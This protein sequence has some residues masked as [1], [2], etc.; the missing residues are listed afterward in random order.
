MNQE[1]ARQLLDG[2]ELRG[3]GT[4]ELFIDG[5][6]FLNFSGCNYLALTNNREL[7][8]AAQQAL[9]EGVGFS[10]YLVHAYGGRDPYFDAVEKEA[11]KFFG[12]EAAVYLPSGYMIG[13][14]GFAAAAPE[15]DV[16]LL[17]E[18]AHWCL[19]DAAKLTEKPI[20]YFAHRSAM[21][22]AEE[23][24]KLA[25]DQRPLVVTDGAFATLGALPPLDEYAALLRPLNGR[26]LVD[27]SHSG[28]VVGESGRGTV[29]HFGVE[30]IAHVGVTLSKAFC[31]QGAVYVGSLECV[32]RARACTPVRGSNSGT[33]ISANVCAAA[34]RFVRANPSLCAKVRESAEYLRNRLRG[35]GLDVPETPTSIV[36]FSH[37][38][39]SDMRAIQE[40]LFDKGIY[41]LHSNYIASGPGGIIRLSVFADHSKKQLD[42]VVQEIQTAL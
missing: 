3:G 38:D 31:G 20:R 1:T 39:F 13:A 25:P 27:E 14:A 42:W 15:Y 2:H 30:D 5:E 11:T 9:D 28:G 17:D 16:I 33:P 34:L 36:S 12:T 10:R 23:L 41:V 6:R 21:A 22:L 19:V 24:E 37:G 32:E 8:D 29:E 26:L 35:I 4:S 18:T 7:R 40:R